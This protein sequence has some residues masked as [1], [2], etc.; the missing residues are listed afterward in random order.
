MLPITSLEYCSW[1][2]MYTR[3]RRICR[4]RQFR[5][6]QW[7]TVQI[8]ACF[9]LFLFGSLY[10]YRVHCA[11]EGSRQIWGSKQRVYR[12]GIQWTCKYNTNIAI[13]DQ[14]QCKRVNW[15]CINSKLQMYLE[16]EIS[17]L[18]HSWLCIC[19]MRRNARWCQFVGD[20]ICCPT[21]SLLIAQCMNPPLALNK[22]QGIEQ[23]HED[24]VPTKRMLKDSFLLRLSF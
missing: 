22:R 18:D 10:L 6:V 16:L 14:D 5:T 3:C 8:H 4:D 21:V 1:T 24:E 20:K 11:V 12:G 13:L 15:K 19:P 7:I 23:L 2:Y 17:I 9:F